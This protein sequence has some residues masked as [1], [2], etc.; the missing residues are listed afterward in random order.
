MSANVAHIVADMGASGSGKTVRVKRAIAGERRL[1]IWDVM[2]E[3]GDHARA[4]P[5]LQAMV[6]GVRGRESFTLRY[7][8]AG[9]PA[10]LKA[11]F[12]VFCSL[13]FTLGNLAMVCEELQTVTGPS[14][15]P[16]GWS[17]CTLR[18]RHRGLR[19][20]GVSQRPASVD[21][22]FFSNATLIRCGRLNFTD[23]IRTMD[24]V[25]GLPRRD[26]TGVPVSVR[27]LKPL[28]YVERDMATGE[29][30]AGVVTFEQVKQK[31]S[32]ARSR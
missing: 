19:I 2:N 5:T 31:K 30:R 6:S 16:A 15:A 9:D 28:E 22:N 17:N 29:V 26:L 14:W 13:A 27:D 4:V 3:Y 20:Y 11:R 12:D 18:G 10:Q 24:G 23:D 32:S 8:P 21:K 1:L 7:V 25:I